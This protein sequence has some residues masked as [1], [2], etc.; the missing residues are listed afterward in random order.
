MFRET[1]KIPEMRKNEK[2]ERPLLHEIK[3]G[4]TLGVEKFLKKRNY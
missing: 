1:R 4:S 3:I 2:F